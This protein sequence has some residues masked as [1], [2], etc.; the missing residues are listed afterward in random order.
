VNGGEILRDLGGAVPAARLGHDPSLDGLGFDP[1]VTPHANLS[2][3]FARGLLRRWRRQNASSHDGIETNDDAVGPALGLDLGVDHLG[4]GTQQGQVFVNGSG[5][6]THPSLGL[7][8]RGEILHSIR[9]SD[10]LDFHHVGG[11]CSD[12]L[13]ENLVGQFVD[14][15]Q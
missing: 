11:L 4:H 5:V 1:A 9:R 10:D 2:H 6:V 3:L 8:Q 13:I 7:E 15:L 14:A 12:D